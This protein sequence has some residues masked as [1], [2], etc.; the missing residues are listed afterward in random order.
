MSQ[1]S[2]DIYTSHVSRYLLA[3]PSERAGLVKISSLRFDM[4]T[5]G[6]IKCLGQERPEEP[7]CVD[8]FAATGQTGEEL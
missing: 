4:T 8:G 6:F 7:G 1:R 3:R 5:P 2:G